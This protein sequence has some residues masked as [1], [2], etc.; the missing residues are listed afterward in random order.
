[1]LFTHSTYSGEPK[2]GVLGTA[3]KSW[4]ELAVV[5]CYA[6][7][8]IPITMIVLETIKPH[9]TI[10]HRETLTEGLQL[11]V[12]GPCMPFCIIFSNSVV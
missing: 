9:N 12:L 3:L 8:A 5:P 1:M 2:I 11:C 6:G 4:F 10:T 7:R